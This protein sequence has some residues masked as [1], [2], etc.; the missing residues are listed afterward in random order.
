LA[1][2]KILPDGNYFYLANESYAH[3]YFLYLKTNDGREI[4]KIK[5]PSVDFYTTLTFSDNGRIFYGDIEVTFPFLRKTHPDI[6]LSSRSNTIIDASGNTY[7]I[8]Y[9]GKIYSSSSDGTPRWTVENLGTISLY[10]AL[11]KDNLL[12]VPFMDSSKNGGLYI[13]DSDSGEI[14]KNVSLGSVKYPSAVSIGKDFIVCMNQGSDIYGSVTKLTKTGEIIKSV[15]TNYDSSFPP[16]I[17]DKNNIYAL[18][19]MIYNFN[20]NLDLVWLSGFHSIYKIIYFKNM[21]FTTGDYSQLYNAPGTPEGDWPQYLHDSMQSGSLADIEFVDP[22]LAPVALTPEDNAVFNTNSVTFSWEIDS[23]DPNIKH[24]LLLRDSSGYDKVYAGPETG[25]STATVN[26][27]A[28]GNYEWRV[29]S[30]DENGSLN[31]SDAQT[32]FVNLP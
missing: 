24:T 27:L 20:E 18:Q 17:F 14:I 15:K 7:T 31:V 1:D 21:I 10:S 8:V 28:A 26:D 19:E 30:K 4:I 6:E 9:S 29:V 3:S 12:Y 11:S 5:P 16:I 2:I 25:L 32:F 13:I 23:S 22:P